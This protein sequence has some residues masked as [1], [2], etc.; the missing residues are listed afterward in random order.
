MI[1]KGKMFKSQQLTIP[2]AIKEAK[3]AVKQGDLLV[4]QKLYC[5]V[6]QH[7]PNQPVAKKELSRLIKKIPGHRSDQKQI[8][9]PS[10]EQI[11]TLLNLYYSGQLTRADQACKEMLRMFPG[12][13]I[14]LNIWGAILRKQGILQKAVKV[15]DRA[16]QLKPDYA[17]AYNNRGNAL[18][19]LGRAQEALDDYSKAIQLRPDYPEAY[20][21]RGNT[22]RDLGRIQE[23]LKDYDRAIQ[24]KPDYTEACYNRGNVHRDL[25]RIQEALKDYDRAIQ[26]KPDYTEAYNNRGVSLKDL[27]RI[28][29]ALSDYNKAIQLKPDY[30]EAYY[31]RGNAFKDLG[32]VQEALNDYNKAIQLKP[33]YAEAYNNR[34]I[35][36]VY[37]DR[38]KEALS[39]YNKA[40]Q[41]KPDDVKAY[42]NRGNALEGLGRVQEALSDYEKAIRL[43]P[44]YVEAYYNRGN[45]LK[46]LDRVQEALND[47]NKAIQL[48]PD[49]AEAY[50][51]RGIS[52]VYF[53]RIQE[54]L[55]D[56]NKAIQLKPDYAMAYNNRG[57]ALKNL[58]RFKAALCDYEKAIQLKPNY[59]E[60]YN[61]RG[62]TLKDIGRVQE[63]LNDYNEAIQLKPDYAEAHRHIS[64]LK[65]YK[66][67]DTQLGIMERLLETDKITES[68]QM[69]LSFALA[70]AYEDI[71]DYDKSFH[72]IKRG[73]DLRKKELNY[74]LEKNRSFINGIR[75]IFDKGRFITQAESDPVMTV[76]IVGMPRS[77]TTLVEQILASHSQVFGAGELDTMNHLGNKSLL[78]YYHQST[79]L[80]NDQSLQRAVKEL[81]DGYLKALIDLQISEKII[82]DKM[83]GNFIWIGFI[84]S[85][86]PEAKII[87]MNRDP[88]ATCWSIYK[89]FFS[90]K[91][92]GYA[93]DMV[94]LAEFYNI[95]VEL[96]A[97]WRDCFPDKIYDLCYEDLTEKQ[98]EET[99]K[100]L[101]YCGLELEA[102]C[103]DFYKTER[104]VRTASATQ[105][106]EKMYT[107]SSKAW[108][109]YAKHIQTM[110]NKL[111]NIG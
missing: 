8:S 68:E 104:I 85:A 44:D 46:N 37:F 2:K 77:G 26:L 14:V 61:N 3:K 72:F 54:A 109:N 47:F 12:S 32:R 111:P 63:A 101:S 49:Y 65:K 53:D 73:N 21:N 23:A 19:D 7:Q 67:D 89:N 34:G 92:N 81:H 10:Q 9:N 13:L 62:N 80:D 15:F 40:I 91:G 55:S 52:F 45:I 102:Q 27:K 35:S 93:Y 76:F 98:E 90:S 48:K 38:I 106:R 97:F 6:L 79:L 69:H 95:Y 64:V 28:Q 100:L 16:I 88:R 17:E 74:S 51:N 94:D 56:Y 108:K 57:N 33:D 83:P 107:G 22:L 30:V 4:A 1:P 75:D 96:M 78:G 20:D 36:L 66:A 86:F 60:A 70:K 58:G 42:N 50:N 59:A 25:G 110:I 5:A 71:K 43:K 29:E 31:N 103:L 11:N 18:K 41:L 82:T 99:R 84:L 24:L 87:N 105:V 39:D